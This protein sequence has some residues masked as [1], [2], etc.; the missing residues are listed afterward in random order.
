MEDGHFIVKSICHEICFILKL[1][2]TKLIFS[3]QFYLFCSFAFLNF[4]LLHFY[5]LLKK[6]IDQLLIIRNIKNINTISLNHF[7]N[8]LLS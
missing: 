6:P 7:F 1:L 4:Y 8:Q 2:E 5:F 3:F